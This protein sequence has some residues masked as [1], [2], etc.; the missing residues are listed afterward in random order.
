M[1]VTI[2][3]E[4]KRPKVKFDFSP[5]QIYMLQ[6]EDFTDPEELQT[7]GKQWKQVMKSLVEK[8]LFKPQGKVGTVFK[9]TA[10]GTRVL[11]QVRQR[12]S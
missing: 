2:P 10:W 8:E 3:A 7:V 1:Q 9:R 5:S 4:G 6:Y 11:K 12:L